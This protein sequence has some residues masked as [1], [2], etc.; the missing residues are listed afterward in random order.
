MSVA[1]F[2]FTGP[3]MVG[4]CLLLNSPRKQLRPVVTHA[5]RIRLL[6]MLRSAVSY[7]DLPDYTRHSPSLWII[8]TK[9]P[10]LCLGFVLLAK[11]KACTER[12]TSIWIKPDF[13]YQGHG[14]ETFHLL[15]SQW[16]KLQWAQSE[17]W[18]NARKKRTSWKNPQTFHAHQKAHKFFSNRQLSTPESFNF[19]IE[20]YHREF[21]IP[22]NYAVQHQLALISEPARLHFAGRDYVSRSLWL[23]HGAMQAWGKMR[24]AAQEN[25]VMLEAVSGFRSIAY[26]ANIVRRKLE[27]GLAIETILKIN[28][29]PGYSEHHSG[30]AIDITVPGCPPAEEIFETTSGFAWLREHAWRFGFRMSYPR[31]N[32]HGVSYEPWHWYWVG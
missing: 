18:D 22:E 9:E 26:Q 25:G 5:D 6:E 10:S 16:S 21:N 19:Y 31:N 24:R 4:S 7:K 2:P 3:N 23:Q 27:R 8:E 14:R 32:P 29:A 13:R 28:T 17:S 20:N 30:R 12:R 15:Q 11:D 1:H